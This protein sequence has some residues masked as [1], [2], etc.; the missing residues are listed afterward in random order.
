MLVSQRSELRTRK[1]EFCKQLT[2]LKAIICC[3]QSDGN[4]ELPNAARQKILTH[5]EA[6]GSWHQAYQTGYKNVKVHAEAKTP[7][8]QPFARTHF[9]EVSCL[10]IAPTGW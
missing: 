6:V 8:S 10:P 4:P 2:Q 7:E 1:L 3:V 9:P 5:T